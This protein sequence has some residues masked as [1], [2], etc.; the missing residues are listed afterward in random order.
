MVPSQH[1]NLVSFGIPEKGML[2]KIA[3]SVGK[4]F[5]RPVILKE[6]RLELGSFF[7]GQRRQYNADLLLQMVEERYA[8]DQ[9]KTIGLFQVDL[10]IPILT[11]IFGQAYLNGQTA[12]ASG[13]RLG[14]ERYGILKTS[15]Q[16]SDRFAKEIIHELGHAFGLVHCYTPS[17]VM[18]AST[19]VEDIDLKNA[20]FCA[21]CKAKINAIG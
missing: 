17:C 15:D 19:Y 9:H 5:N 18:Q 11:Y 14:N 7:D 21:K 1:I 3:K 13:Y 10:F 16:L 12:V 6:A 4:A 2:D 8:S 20:E